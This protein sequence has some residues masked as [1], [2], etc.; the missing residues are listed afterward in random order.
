MAKEGRFIAAAAGDGQSLTLVQQPRELP[1]IPLGLSHQ[2][3]RMAVKEAIRTAILEGCYL[4]GDRLPEEELAAELDVSRNPVREAL[5]SL[6]LDGFVEI[7]PRRG[8]R[9][10][11][12]SAERAFQL[13]EVR[14]SLEGLVARLA[15]A[16]RSEEQLE[17]M[18]AYVRQGLD[19]AKAGRVEALPALNSRFHEVLVEAAGNLI[20]AEMLGR[21]SPVIAWV[22][23]RRIAQRSRTSWSEHDEIVQ[24]I[25]NRDEQRAFERACAHIANARAAY[26][27][28]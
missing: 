7:M 17:R 24:A 28:A 10:A 4:P 18:R 9:V 19:E 3:L 11:M 6:T 21:L 23:S 15:A 13:F 1:R 20:L 26:L 14:E 12:V 16:R 27:S 5:Q 8:A 25:A 2:P 22:Y